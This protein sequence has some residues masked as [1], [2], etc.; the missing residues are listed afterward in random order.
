MSEVFHIVP[1]AARWTWLVPAG[2]LSVVLIGGLTLLGLSMR[3]SKHA[4]FEVS[5]TGLRVRGDLYGRMLPASQLRGGA[6]RIVDFDRERSLRPQRKTVGT[7]IPGYRS[8]WFRLA[9]GEKALLYLTD[10]RRAVYIPTRN[11][12]VLLLSVDRPNEFVERLRAIA[13]AA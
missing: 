6:A 9:N 5:P 11:G 4:T 8:G 13:P 2:L 12:Y 3:G 1:A 10:L 7:A